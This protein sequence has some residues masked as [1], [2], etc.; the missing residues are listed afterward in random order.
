MDIK[1]ILE[2]FKISKKTMRWIIGI[3]VTAVGIAFI[4]GGKKV[5]YLNEFEDLKNSNKENKELLI[6]LKTDINHRFDSL[7]KVVDQKFE[8]SDSKTIEAIT[9]LQDNTNDQ[10]QFIIDHREE[11]KK[12][13]KDALMMSQKNLNENITRN[14]ENNINK[15]QSNNKIE[16]SNTTIVKKDEY[17]KAYGISENDF[18]ELKKKFT[19]LKSEKKGAKYDVIYLKK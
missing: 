15:I 1:Q 13:L 8:T 2:N 14:I 11:D 18:N 17:M 16:N 3:L 5:T 12:L 6:E 10:L 4:I 19:I 7:E 9:N